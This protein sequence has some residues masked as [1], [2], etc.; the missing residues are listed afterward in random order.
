MNSTTDKKAGRAG[1]WANLVICGGLSWGVNIW[2]AVNISGGANWRWILAVMFGTAPVVVAAI[3]SH[4]ISRGGVGTIKTVITYAVFAMGMAL[5]ITAQAAA[6]APFA[7]RYNLNWVFPIMLDVA[8]FLSLH[9]LMDTAQNTTRP[10]SNP[11]SDMVFDTVQN[12]ALD[13]GRPSTR[14]VSRAVSNTPAVPAQSTARPVTDTAPDTAR[15]V[16]SMA[17]D[18]A[19]DTPQNTGPDTTRAVSD[20]PADTALNTPRNT[21]RNTPARRAGTPRARGGKASKETREEAARRIY[22]AHMA[23]KHEVI[24]NAALR[25]ALSEAGHPTGNRTAADLLV[26]FKAHPLRIAR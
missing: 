15:P 2:H 21:T 20:T 9:S 6:V 24:S 26:E 13:T 8:T 14:P 18:M 23:D 3:Q 16:S 1:S 4:Q 11:V 12:T 7:P 17:S 5:S 19:L 10:V 22:D 25:K